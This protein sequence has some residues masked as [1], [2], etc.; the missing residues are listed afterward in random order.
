MYMLLFGLLITLGSA[1]TDQNPE[2]PGH[3]GYGNNTKDVKYDRSETVG[4]DYARVKKGMGL[5]GKG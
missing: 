1:K 4:Q 5:R 3:S 2:S